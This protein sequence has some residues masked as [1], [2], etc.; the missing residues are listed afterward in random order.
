MTAKPCGAPAAEAAAVRSSTTS[1]GKPARSRAPRN[2]TAPAGPRRPA[3][4]TAPVGPTPRPAG[5]RTAPQVYRPVVVSAV[6]LAARPVRTPEQA[7]DT[8]YVRT[9]T[10]LLR[11]LELLTG[12]P[13]LARRALTHAFDQA[14]QRWPEVARDSDPVGWVRSA[15]YE[16]ALAPWHRWLPPRRE[17][18]SPAAPAIAPGSGTATATDPTSAAGSAGAANAGEG[19]A[20]GSGTPAGTATAA[21]TTDPTP[22]AGSGEAATAEAGVRAE[23]V[24]PPPDGGL[25]AAFL[26]LPPGHRRALMLYDGLGLDLPE[27]AAELEASTA[28]TAG[29]IMRAREALTGAVPELAAEEDVPVRLGALLDDSPGGEPPQGP[30]DVRDASERGVRLRTVGSFALT[31]LIALVTLL[32]I[33]LGPDTGGPA[34]HPATDGTLPVPDAGTAGR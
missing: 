18:P 16:Y 33:L 7:F 31:G 23:P 9:A 34:H 2:A 21:T 14:W 20:T 27:A 10:A 28:A 29:R 12:D 13:V 30:A 26:G 25:A 17:R 3:K 24:V 32:V 15:A 6:A 1:P 8:L 22:T 4:P 5:G 19:A 11:Q